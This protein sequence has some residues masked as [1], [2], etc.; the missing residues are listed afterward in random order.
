MV[1][2]STLSVGNI[3]V[4]VVGAV[5]IIGAIVYFVNKKRNDKQEI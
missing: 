3:I 4:V 5:V 1:V 2:Y